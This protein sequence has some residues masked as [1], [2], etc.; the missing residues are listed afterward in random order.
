MTRPSPQW[1]TAIYNGRPVEDFVLRKLSAIPVRKSA[2][3]NLNYSL[4]AC[5]PY[6]PAP[7]PGASVLQFD[8]NA[9]YLEIFVT[10]PGQPEQSLTGIPASEFLAN[11]KNAR[12]GGTYPR[13]ADPIAGG[14]PGLYIVRLR[15]LTYRNPTLTTGCFPPN[16]GY[17]GLQIDASYNVLLD[18]ETNPSLP[19]P[20]GSWTWY[21]VNY[22]PVFQEHIWE[23]NV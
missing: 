23:F 18:G 16:P 14:P 12:W 5:C 19:A 8:P 3:F 4:A 15:A 6:I 7:H 17:P 21:G 13:A 22:Q 11:S 10:K 2:L 9:N 1:P 20:D